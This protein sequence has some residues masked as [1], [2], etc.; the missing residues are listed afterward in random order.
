MRRFKTLIAAFATL[1]SL[2]G[3]AAAIDGTPNAGFLPIKRAAAAPEGATALCRTYDWACAGATNDAPAGADVVKLAAQV[4]RAAN[5]KIRPITDQKQYAVAER[6]TLPSQR[7]G[8]C[9]DYALYKKQAL[10]KAGISPDRL[11]IAAVLDR[12]RQVHAV[13]ILRSDLGDFVLDN[14]TNRVLG[15]NQTGYTFL[16]MQDPRQPS[17]WVATFVQAGGGLNS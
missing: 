12:K 16:R 10:I 7:G 3:A 17:Q 11:L 6:W 2:A 15:W 9:E 8:D 4:N 5:A 1:V 13:L 14:M